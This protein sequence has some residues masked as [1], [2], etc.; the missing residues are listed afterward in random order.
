MTQRSII[1]EEMRSYLGKESAPVVVE[2]DKTACRIFARAV[3]YTDPVF[4]D[5]EFAKSKGYR[6]ILAPPGFLGHTIYNPA[7]PQRLDYL[8]P[9]EIP[10][11]RLLNGGNDLQYFDDICA[12]DV[13]TATSKLVDLQEREGRLG[14]MLITVT[15]ITYR[16]GDKVVAVMRGTLISY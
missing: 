15:E 10:Y 9:F 2:V 1:T 8:P 3:G 4:Y 6:S 13:L 5:E 16:R 11:K 7:R 12:G 14:P